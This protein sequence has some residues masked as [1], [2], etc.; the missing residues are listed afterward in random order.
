[1][2]ATVQLPGGL[3]VDGQLHRTAHIGD[4]TGRVER[5][6]AGCRSPASTM[7][8]AVSAV[9]AAAVKRIGTVPVSTDIAA[10]LAVGDRIFLMLQLAMRYLGDLVWLSPICERCAQPF[11]VPVKRSQLSVRKPADDYP[12]T[13]LRLNGHEIRLR[14]PCGE[15][16]RLIAE[17]RREDAGSTLLA[18]CIQSVDGAEPGPEYVATLDASALRKI[19]AALQR[20]GPDVD[21]G[22]RAKCAEC[23]QVQRIELEPYWL[24]DPAGSTLEVEVHRLASHYHWSESDILALPSK[25]RRRYCALIDRERGGRG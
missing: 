9:L 3:W 1:M 18:C 2:S 24:G 25:L 5:A 23:E 7:P 4:L 20:A 11:D 16:Q 14:P 15:D 8:N 10:C 19:E 6:F 12:T 17:I 22:V 21:C 13:T